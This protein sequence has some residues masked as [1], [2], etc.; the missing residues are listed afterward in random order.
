MKKIFIISSFLFVLLSACESNQKQAQIQDS[1][2][3]E[4][5]DALKQEVIYANKQLPISI[6]PYRMQSMDISGNYYTV[7]IAA[8]ENQIDLDEY[9]DEMIKDRTNV[10]ALVSGN[11][12]DF[13]AL[14]VQSGLN[15]KLVIS[16]SQSNR[17]RIVCLTADEIKRCAESDYDAK[18]YLVEMVE[19]INQ[20][21]PEDQGDGLLLTS[22][23]IEGN[24][25]VYKMLTDESVVTVD[26]IK[27]SISESND[28]EISILEEFAAATDPSEQMFF[29]YLKEC[30]MGIKYVYWTKH[31]NDSAVINLS[32]AKIEMAIKDK[33]LY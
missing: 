32:P 4:A 11:H 24:D 25:I 8:D 14:L 21:L 16:G 29:K 13:A 2:Q 12:K 6:G 17:Q 33:A 15:L 20:G 3:N 9:A 22:L 7:Y 18:D 27:Q 23:G 19:E 5:L 26:M 1:I 30:G 31:S 28:I 10:I